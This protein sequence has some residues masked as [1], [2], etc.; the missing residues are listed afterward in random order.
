MRGG[1]CFE[2]GRNPS[3]A[4]GGTDPIS[5]SPRSSFLVLCCI[6][7][8]VVHVMWPSVYPR[9]V[10]SHSARRAGLSARWV[11]TLNSPCGP[12]ESDQVVCD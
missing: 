12:F 7:I 5:S 11:K 3:N 1:T 2:N 8:I 4:V 6:W 10:L 9:I